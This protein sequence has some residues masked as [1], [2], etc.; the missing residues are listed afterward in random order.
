MK[1]TLLFISIIL[2]LLIALT[3]CS[4]TPES[5]KPVTPA[6]PDPGEESPRFGGMS[7]GPTKEFSVGQSALWIYMTVTLNDGITFTEIEGNMDVTSWFSGLPSGVKAKTY[8]MYTE[9][10]DGGK[11]KAAVEKEDSSP[12]YIAVREGE[13]SLKLEF[14]GTVGEASSDEF[15]LVIPSSFTSAG[16]DIAIEIKTEQSI[17]VDR[18]IKVTFDLGGGTLDGRPSTW[19]QILSSKGKVDNPGTPTRD[20]YRFINWARQ[21]ETTAFDFY[22]TDITESVTIVALWDS[23][24]PVAPSFEEIASASDDY[25]VTVRIYKNNIQGR[26]WYTVNGED[27]T[28]DSKACPYFETPYLDVKIMRGKTIK[29][30]SRSIYGKQSETKEHKTQKFLEYYGYGTETKSHR[31]STLTSLTYP[32]RDRR[33]ATFTPAVG[34]LD[35][36]GISTAS[37]PSTYKNGENDF[38]IM[39]IFDC[40]DGRL[41]VVAKY[42]YKGVTTNNRKIFYYYIEKTTGNRTSD[43]LVEIPSFSGECESNFLYHKEYVQLIGKKL[44]FACDY[45]TKAA[46]CSYNLDTKEQKII[47]YDAITYANSIVIADTFTCGNWMYFIGNITGGDCYV[48]GLNTEDEATWQ[49]FKLSTGFIGL[50]GASDG[51]YLY[52]AVNDGGSTSQ[53]YNKKKL[54]TISLKDS[55]KDITVCSLETRYCG[56]TGS[57]MI[58]DVAVVNGSLIIAGSEGDYETENTRLKV[59]RPC[60]WTSNGKETV[61]LEKTHFPIS[62]GYITPHTIEVLDGRV[63]ILTDNHYDSNGGNNLPYYTENIHGGV[64]ELDSRRIWDFGNGFYNGA[65]YTRVNYFYI[66]NPRDKSRGM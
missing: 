24:E 51:D 39:N 5:G 41:L 10:T 33:I 15:A 37:E 32:P 14:T 34:Y 2:T 42:G 59:M 13:G 8:T 60:I 23:I 19:V 21:G 4:I 27:P 29:A 26:V 63:Y 20:G 52:V 38:H 62:C 65:L 11:S 17:I 12:R 35:D 55:G 7:T 16:H 25:D 22:Y 56:T 6:A 40:G 66:N 36:I 53:D 58:G 28:V 46:L 50:K 1:K 9:G 57:V 45:Q 44:Y 3:A 64:I 47:S 43:P 54:V 48:W 18:R 31:E 61:L 30:F 49:S